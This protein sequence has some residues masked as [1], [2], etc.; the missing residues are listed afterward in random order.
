MI[1]IIIIIYQASNN[2]CSNRLA[3]F[4]FTFS[5]ALPR[6]ILLSMVSVLRS[7]MNYHFNNNKK[8][9]NI[10]ET[11]ASL[12]ALAFF[13]VAGTITSTTTM[14]GLTTTTIIQ[15]A[16]AYMDPN[17]LKTEP[18]APVV[19][20]GDNIYIA[21]WTDKGTP[22]TNGEVMFRASNDGG[23]TFGD[24]MN[25]SNTTNADSTRAEIAAEGAD[26]VV[27]WWESNQT[28]GDTPVARISDDGG[29]TFG[30]M[31]RLGANGT[32]TS[33]EEGVAEGETTEEEA[34]GGA[35]VAE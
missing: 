26:V 27:T 29:Q 25:L 18:K 23:A 31:L 21:W 20:S 35:E 12:F 34:V 6:R 5:L 28:S 10:T 8:K 1:I 7:E 13:I 11:A 17:N 19:I 14:I 32:L 24:K 4:V 2:H 30:P 16:E 33:T 22:N 15:S 3:F 9:D